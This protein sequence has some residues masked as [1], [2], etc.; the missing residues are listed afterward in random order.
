MLSQRTTRRHV[1]EIGGLSL[2]GLGTGDLIR[3]RQAAADGQLS[4]AAPRAKSCV[5]L[6]LFGG[7]SQL[8]SFD[9]KSS[10]GSAYMTGL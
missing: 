1:L 4:K 3:L 9:M 5:F 6:F 2:L 7:P 10:K 8:E